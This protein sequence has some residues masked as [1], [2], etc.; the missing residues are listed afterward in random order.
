MLPPLT[1][2]DVTAIVKIQLQAQRIPG[3]VPLGAAGIKEAQ[4]QVRRLSQLYRETSPFMLMM[5]IEALKSPAAYARTISHGHLLRLAV[6]QR[7]LTH[8]PGA[9]IFGD[10]PDAEYVKDFLSAVACTARRNGQRNAVQLV[11]NTR[12]TTTSQLQDFLNIWLSDNEVD[13]SN[14]TQGNI[15]KFLRIAL[16]AGIITIS[17]N[18]VLSFMHELI[19]EYF[20]AE[21]LRLVYHRKDGDDELFWQSIHESEVQAA[22]LWSEPVAI[23]AGLED[24]PIEIARFLMTNIDYYCRQK[25]MDADDA[26]F[27]HYHAMALSLGCLGVRVSDGLP[28]ETLAYLKR[29]VLVKEKHEQ[30]ALIF[31]RC[32]DE[33]G[34]GVYQALLPTIHIPGLLDVF[35]KIHDLY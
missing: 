15:G 4:E 23:W 20:A 26:D 19:A 24:K 6:D 28:D 32:A 17:N 11:K 34:I 25:D 13:V 35:L 33:G 9:L 21:Y 30:L 29:S 31:K 27:Y 2:D 22:G 16:D 5:L 8:E 10:H 12:F 1:A 3:Q 7:P 18:G 14:F